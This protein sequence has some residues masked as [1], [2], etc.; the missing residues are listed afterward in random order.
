MNVTIVNITK[1]ANLRETKEKKRN[2]TQRKMPKSL[3][4]AYCHK[5]VN[6]CSR[7]SHRLDEGEL[8]DRVNIKRAW[9][10]Q[11]GHLDQ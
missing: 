8:E 7:G 1:Q 5:S 9:E 11:S 10:L 2:S 3:N 6:Y 4:K